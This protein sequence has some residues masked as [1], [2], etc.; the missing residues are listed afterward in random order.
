METMS[1]Y[2]HGQGR[3]AANAAALQHLRTAWYLDH[4]HRD[5]AGR[6]LAVGRACL[7]AFAAQSVL[8]LVEEGH[9]VVVATHNTHIRM[10]VIEHEGDLGLFPQ[11]Y[12]LAQALGDGYVSIAATGS[13]GRTAVT[14]VTP[15]H[16]LGV[17]SLDNPF[18]PLTDD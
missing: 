17:E 8:R 2:Q 4:G 10:T 11:C 18:P 9:R 7:D 13:S 6:G 14:Q 3:G 12:H 5:L 1:G 15:D 16:P